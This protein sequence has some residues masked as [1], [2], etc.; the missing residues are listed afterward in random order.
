MKYSLLLNG[1]NAYAWY[2]YKSVHVIGY[3]FDS[4]NTLYTN[5]DAATYIVSQRTT[6]S[7][8]ELSQQIQGIYTIIEI[9]DVCISVI[10]DSVNY[11]PVFYL[12]TKDV[13]YVSDSWNALID[14]KHGVKTNSQ[15]FAEFE[16]AGFVLG[17]QT[18]D[19]DILKTR[20]WECLNII[21][22]GTYSRTVIGDFLPKTFFSETFNDAQQHAYEVYSRVGAR[23]VSYLNQRTAVVPLSGGFDS[24]LIV[25]LLYA[26]G[27]SN[28][29]CFTYGKMNSEVPLSKQVAQTLGYPWYFIDYTTISKEPLKGSDLEQYLMSAANGFAMPYLQEYYA[30]RE[31]KQH[32]L[33]PHDSVFLPGHSG[34][35]LGG[36]YIT[37]TIQASCTFQQIPAHIEQKYF[38]FK[39]KSKREQLHVQQRIANTLEIQNHSEIAG[40]YNPI[41]ED[42]DIK[43]KLSKFIF[44]SSYVF[45]FFGYEHYFP[46]WDKELVEFYRSVP[47]EFRTQK[48]L[49]DKVACVYY[50]EPQGI[51]FQ[52]SE[53]LVRKRDF[54]FQKIKDAIRY[55]FPWR[56][57]LKRMIAADWMHYADL[58][59]DMQQEIGQNTGKTFTHF[60]TFN[61][62][63]C[64][65]YINVNSM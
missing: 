13:W 17:N 42:W 47:Y 52:K 8:E 60:K 49:Y 23:L 22:N 37:K 18:L 45:N 48:V 12:F 56:I 33:I 26:A 3:F 40:G 38:F 53:L 21:P 20:A 59:K 54:I 55:F 65:W 63:I 58:T 6:M 25:S 4:A 7:L 10:T 27:Y 39:K 64:K 57:V 11:F 29:V 51:S 1:N 5:Q 15:A 32:G 2:S 16:C 34:D 46:L 9:S 41:I 19:S 62:V 36:S 50:F 28:V 43:E 14:I 24:R 30:V 61:A 44:H 31:L 35:Y